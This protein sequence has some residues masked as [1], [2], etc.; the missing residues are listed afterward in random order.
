[1]NFYEKEKVNKM[2]YILI[3]MGLRFVR[4]TSFAEGESFVILKAFAV[5]Q[6]S[7]ILRVITAI[8]SFVLWPV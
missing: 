6:Y 4:L 3:G 7:V 1:M 8:Q 5:D 2:N